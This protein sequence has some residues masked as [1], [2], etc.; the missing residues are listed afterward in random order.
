MNDIAVRGRKILKKAEESPYYFD[1]KSVLTFADPI[2]QP[3]SLFSGYYVVDEL[4][5]VAQGKDCYKTLYNILHEI[6]VV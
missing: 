6:G 3:C 1:I 4:L 2:C 5:Y